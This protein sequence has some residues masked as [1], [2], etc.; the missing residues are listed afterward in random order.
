MEGKNKT[1]QETTLDTCISVTGIFIPIEKDKDRTRFY[2]KIK[3]VLPQEEGKGWRKKHECLSH[4]LA[5]ISTLLPPSSIPPT[6][7]KLMGQPILQA[8]GMARN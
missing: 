5:P 4:H 8:D 7:W 1:K 6:S 2:S 3:V